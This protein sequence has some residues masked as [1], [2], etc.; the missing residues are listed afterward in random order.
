M[1]KFNYLILALFIIVGN[2]DLDATLF[3]AANFVG[4]QSY[5]MYIKGQDIFGNYTLDK[6]IYLPAGSASDITDIG[7][8]NS[9]DIWIK[10]G[11]PEKLIKSAKITRNKHGFYTITDQQTGSNLCNSGLDAAPQTLVLNFDGNNITCIYSA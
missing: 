11:S 9:A 10:A 3:Q 6:K 7:Y 5:N 2:S 1:N 8:T 4:N